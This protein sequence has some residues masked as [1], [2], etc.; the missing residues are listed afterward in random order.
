MP[1]PELTSSYPFGILSTSQESTPLSSHACHA[2]HEPSQLALRFKEWI[3]FPFT[4]F[5]GRE[6][7]DQQITEKLMREFMATIC[8]T[9]TDAR[10]STR[11]FA[12]Q[13][14]SSLGER[15]SVLKNW[16]GPKERTVRRCKKKTE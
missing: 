1:Y 5:N 16:L 15:K 11:M 10:L 12:L 13:S 14:L 4:V 7:F 2:L 8:E 9:W 3:S 6:K